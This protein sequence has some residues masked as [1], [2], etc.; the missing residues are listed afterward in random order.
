MGG[1]R[2]IARPMQ[3]WKKNVVV[4]GVPE[5]GSGFGFQCRTPF[6]THRACRMDV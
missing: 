5:T 3:S 1:L 6:N 2:A 4:F